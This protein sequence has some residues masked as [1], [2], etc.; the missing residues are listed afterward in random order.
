VQRLRVELARLRGEID[1]GEAAS[2][3]AAADDAG[4]DGEPEEDPL[5]AAEDRALEAEQRIGYLADELA[6]ERRALDA[7]RARMAALEEAER[8]R[9]AELVAAEARLASAGRGL[10]QVE[11]LEAALAE[12]REARLMLETLRD[13]L[14]AAM[15]RQRRLA[16]RELHDVQEMDEATR[17]ELVLGHLKEVE[18]VRAELEAARAECAG[19][20]A[21]LECESE[22]R[23]RL[24][25]RARQLDAEIDELRHWISAVESRRRGI[26]R[27]DPLPPVPARSVPRGPAPVSEPDHRMT[28]PPQ[29]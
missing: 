9:S 10:E 21:D 4:G 1:E 18:G 6:A 28:P 20:R 29:T 23:A 24:E 11:R 13:G 25:G 7:L 5:A 27:R 26:F 12:E 8:E 14:E 2:P 22:V 17:A 16:E 19:L 15:E 3:G